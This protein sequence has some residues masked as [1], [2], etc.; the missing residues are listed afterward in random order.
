MSK[1]GT[2]SSLFLRVGEKNAPADRKIDKGEVL[3]MILLSDDD[4]FPFAVIMKH[5]VEVTADG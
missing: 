2:I 4:Y 5:I 1:A 3:P